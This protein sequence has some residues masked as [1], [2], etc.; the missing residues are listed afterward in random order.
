MKN[1][2]LNKRRKSIIR[3]MALLGISIISVW[4]FW[5]PQASGVDTTLIS[6]GAVWKYLDNGSNQGTAW[7]AVSFNDST[8]ASGPAQLGYGDGDEAT[9]VG[10]GPD[11]LNRYITTYFRRSFTVVDASIY[12]SLNLR[13]LRDDGGVAYLNG[14]EV[15]RSNMPAGA[16]G[17]TTPASSNIGGADESTF[18]TTSVSPSLLVN[19]TN[20]V[21]VEIH[22]F[23]GTSSDISFDLDLV[24]SD[25]VT[26]TRGPY[27]QKGTP[28]SVVVRWRTNVARDSRVH[29]GTDLANL[30][31]FADGGVI[32]MNPQVTLTGLLANTKYFYSIGTTTMTLAGGDANHFFF[33]SPAAGAHKPTRI[34]VIG[35][36][37][38]A[39]ADAAAVR[40][41]YLAYTGTRYTD[42]W[43]MLG[44]NAYNSGT[45]SEYEAAVFDMYPTVLRQTVLWPTLGN[46]DGITADSATQTGPYYD[47]FTLP[48]LGEA[49]GLASGTEAYYSFDYGDIHFIC[50]E[51]FETSRATAGAMMTWL[52][53]DLAS[54]TKT[55]VI[56]FWHHPPY[57]KGSHN[58]DLEIEL[59]EMRQNA[60]PLLEAEG[61]DLVLTGHSHSYE[62]SF[63]IDG[64]YGNSTTFLES[65][66]KETGSGREDGTGA[67]DKVTIGPGPHE[68][69]VYAVAGSSGLIS[70]GALNHPA[71][72]VSMNNLGSMVLD[73][74][75]TRLNAVFL[76][77]LGVIRDYFTILKGIAFDI[78]MTQSTYVNGETVVASEFRPRNP[79]SAP[80]AVRLRVW[81]SV[82]GLGDVTMVDVGADGSF[83][84]PP[85]LNQN[86]GPLS[87][88]VVTPTFPPKGNWQFNSR[89]ENPTTGALISEDINAFV[90]Q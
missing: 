48:T 60:L 69:A 29:Y 81:L 12:T 4:S 73:I 44:D 1:A 6:T 82:P 47:I 77:N 61:V 52:A 16:I 39:N 15:F 9:V 74:D 87:L 68:G 66:K 19:G 51:S 58:S 22:Q 53:S 75:H 41:A 70:G 85:S 62:R 79:T 83:F 86:I 43:L 42:L 45:D 38:T 49:G 8:W 72:F 20:V 13:L 40:D 55:W 88:F 78:T 10:F 3:L 35:D 71:M 30:T 34:W 54:T 25:T 84:L 90:I 18:Y 33:T 5:T 67:Y 28:A 26:V 80:A 32:T 89:I 56:A 65:M 76:D 57:S 24:G 50:L 17:Y 21:A 11:P 23:N 63:F 31:A 27:L 37:G 14:T 2:I 7:T 59:I 46:H 36:S 64:H